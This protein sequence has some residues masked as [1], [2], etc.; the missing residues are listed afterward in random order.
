[1]ANMRWDFTYAENSVWYLILSDDKSATAVLRKEDGNYSFDFSAGHTRF[2]N[3]GLKAI[4][5]FDAM[6]EVEAIV[7]KTY[8]SVLKSCLEQTEWV[9]SRLSC[10]AVS[11]TSEEKRLNTAINY[12]Y[13]DA[14]NYKVK[15]RCVINGV[16]DEEQ[17]KMI[18]SCLEAGEYFIPQLVGLTERRF[19]EYDPE[20]DHPFMEMD[21]DAFELTEEGNDVSLT[22]DELVN[23]FLL[24]KNN[25][26]ILEHGTVDV[27]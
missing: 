8:E 20:R 5:L 24:Q 16:L 15:N 14:D 23:R 18:L 27:G 19:D 26:N 17:Q 11:G 6:K 9:K 4:S 25:W 7:C 1:M 21:S 12:L 22:P 13:R 10:M 3:H 2:I